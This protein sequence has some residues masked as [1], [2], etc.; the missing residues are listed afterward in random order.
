MSA[1]ALS[2]AVSRRPALAALVGVLFLTLAG[3]A[4]TPADA[5]PTTTPG[6]AGYGLSAAPISAA[7][8]LDPALPRTGAAPVDVLVSGRPGH[9]STVAA[10]VRDHGGTVTAS[11]PMID[12]V[13]ASLPAGQLAEVASSAAVTAVTANRTMH[14]QGATYDETTAGT[15]SNFANSTGA[16]S[17][18]TTDGQGQ[19][20]GVAVLDT[21]VSP[22]NDLSG[23][24]VHG[25]DLSGEGTI[26]DSYGHGTVM[27]G[28][29]AGNGADSA[30][31]AGGPLTGMAP[32]A[33]VVAVKVAGRNGATDVSTVLQGMH[34]VSAYKDQFNIRV[35]NLAW[36]TP[37]TQSPALDP[38]NYAVE[39][40]WQR[41]ITV[42]VAAGN[43]GPTRGTVLKPG[44]DP[45][46]LTVG[47][48]DDKQNLDPRDD[49]VSPWSS[50]GPTAEGYAKPDLVALLRFGGRDGPPEGAGVAE[51]HQGQRYLRGGRRHLRCRG[52]AAAGEARAHPGP[53]EAGAHLGRHA[54]RGPDRVRA[55]RRPAERPCR[56]RR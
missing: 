10:A 38:L 44:D 48:Y 15:G 53:G 34:W 1:T 20:V 42:V 4:V 31:R 19:G 6:T 47:A 26:I 7:A 8:K 36:G 14:F 2:F 32:K 37:S 55:G 17:L 25:P 51:L 46:V 18:W 41:G 27:A 13:R 50:R 3:P 35:L 24:I 22:M 54:D 11:L 28:I 56:P 23:R 33:T 45:L 40:L 39:R 49:S 29:I 16:S 52:A 5:V 21:G 30:G 43:E 12:G 9:S